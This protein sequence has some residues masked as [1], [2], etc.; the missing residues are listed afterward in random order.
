[1]AD[2]VKAG[3]Q[4]ATVAQIGFPKFGI[5]ALAPVIPDGMLGFGRNVVDES[6]DEIG[7]LENLEVAFGRMVGF[8]A[9]DD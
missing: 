4:D 5:A 7:G 9:V 6:G 1:L 8:G 3:N 2:S